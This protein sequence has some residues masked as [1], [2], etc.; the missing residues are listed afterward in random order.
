VLPEKLSQL[1]M[2]ASLG[3]GQRRLLKLDIP[4]AKIRARG[5]KGRCSGAG[6]IYQSAEVL[7]R[8]TGR[9]AATG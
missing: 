3:G 2:S 1:H 8:Q 5:D 7:D 9:S 6:S 4:R